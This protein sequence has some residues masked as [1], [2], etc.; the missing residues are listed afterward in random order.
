LFHPFSIIVPVLVLAPNLV[1]FLKKPVN[2]PLKQPKEPLVLL[3]FERLGQLGCF[4]S[5]VFY[6]INL[7]GI[8]EILG[9]CGMLLMLSI[10]YTGWVRFFIRNRE[11]RWLYYPMLSIP[12]P[13]ALS[14]VLYFL[15]A[16]VILHSLPLLISSLIL[17]AG[18]IPISMINYRHTR[19]N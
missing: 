12:V 13:L 17:A 2:V 4:I 7:S 16:S 3:V 14:P 18:H 10:Y 5:P 9:V 11:Y 6:P 8:S 1:F 19:N 15:L